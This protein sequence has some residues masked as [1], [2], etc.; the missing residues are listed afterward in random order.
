MINFPIGVIITFD[1]FLLLLNYFFV[2]SCHT[3]L[4]KQPIKANDE[5]CDPY[6][7][8]FETEK[9]LSYKNSP[10]NQQIFLIL[11][12]VA[13]H[14]IG[15]Y[16]KTFDILSSINID[17]FAGMLPVNKVSYY[18]NL[19]DICMVLGK[20]EQANIWYIKMA[21]MYSDIKDS[22]SKKMLEPMMQAA[23]ASNIFRMGDYKQVVDLL[24]SIKCPNTVSAVSNAMLCAQAYLK[25]DA[26]EQAKEKL[27]FVIEKGNKLYIVTEAKDILQT[28][29]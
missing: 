1:L 19:S 28:L 16:S 29:Q 12:C 23:T 5:N 13:L 15:E 2:N 7:L 6:P 4:L 11:K 9:L 20:N 8:L 27:E 3:A 21:Q 22:K 24:S 25:L 14:N 26:K 10:I 17:K 18:N